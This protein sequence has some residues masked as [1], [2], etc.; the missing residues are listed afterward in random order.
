MSGHLG[1]QFWNIDLYAYLLFEG[2]LLQWLEG[3]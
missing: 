3:K 1:T 2:G